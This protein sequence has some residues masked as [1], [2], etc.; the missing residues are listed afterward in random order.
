MSDVELV[1][2]SL[3]GT[4]N[5][6]VLA[7]CAGALRAYLV[8]RGDDPN[9]ALVASVPMSQRRPEQAGKTGNAVSA[10]LVPLATELDDPR[11]RYDRIVAHTRTAKER[12]AQLRSGELLSEWVTLLGPVLSD[13]LGWLGSRVG[14][15]LAAGQRQLAANVIIS[16]IPGPPLRVYAAGL[17]LT[18]AFPLGPIHDG[19]PLNITVLSYGD[20]LHVG[21]LACPGA[22]PDIDRLARYFPDAL[23]DLC[24]QC[25]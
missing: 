9:A 2:K 17:P 5:D 22:V 20:S 4:V 6:V 19:V 14:R 18:A 15:V 13:G 1:R 12:E 3:G 11:Q 25:D 16:N 21:L 24:A 23:N 8:G 10:L 7:V